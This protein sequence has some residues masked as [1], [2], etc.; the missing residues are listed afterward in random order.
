MRLAENVEILMTFEPKYRI[1]FRKRTL[2]GPQYEIQE[3]RTYFRYF[4]KWVGTHLFTRFDDAKMVLD[5]IE[6]Q[7]KDGQI[8]YVSKPNE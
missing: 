1:I 4:T 8:I 7:P 2:H 6:K 3:K 5:Y